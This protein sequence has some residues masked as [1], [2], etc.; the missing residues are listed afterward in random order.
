MVKANAL[1]RRG[2]WFGSQ[3]RQM[4]FVSE[5]TSSLCVC[6]HV[7]ALVCVW[8]WIFGGFPRSVRVMSIYPC[9]EIYIKQY[10]QYD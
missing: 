5:D 7:C 6:A 8:A 9:C 2:Q 3:V 10:I 1:H 4:T